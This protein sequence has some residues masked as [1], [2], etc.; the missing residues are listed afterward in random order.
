M[1]NPEKEMPEYETNSKCMIGSNQ[2][3]TTEI[4]VAKLGQLSE[5][6]DSSRGRVRSN[7]CSRRAEFGNDCSRGQVFANASPA[8]SQRYF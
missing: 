5:F 8:R 7:D 3:S 6:S 1:L 2:Q 4:I